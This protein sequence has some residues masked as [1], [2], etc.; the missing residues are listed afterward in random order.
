M[1]DNANRQ[2]KITKKE[3]EKRNEKK[4]AKGSR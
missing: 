1:E 2:Q 3:N 4:K